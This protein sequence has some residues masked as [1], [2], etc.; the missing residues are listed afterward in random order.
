MT[1]PGSFLLNLRGLE[2]GD[3]SEVLFVKVQL[4]KEILEIL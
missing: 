3:G 1:S 2:M 4:G